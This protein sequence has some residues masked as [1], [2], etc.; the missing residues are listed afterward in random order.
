MGKRYGSKAEY[1]RL[2]KAA[3]ASDWI[4]ADLRKRAWEGLAAEAFGRE[5]VEQARTA[6]R[7]VEG[8]AEA[9]DFEGARFSYRVVT[10]PGVRLAGDPTVHDPPLVPGEV[11]EVELRFDAADG[12]R[13]VNRRVRLPAPDLPPVARCTLP[14]PRRLDDPL[15]RLV[16]DLVYGPEGLAEARREAGGREP[17]A[18]E[19]SVVTEP[20]QPDDIDL[21]P[22]LAAGEVIDA[23]LLVREADDEDAAAWREEIRAHLGLGEV[24][25]ER[26]A[27]RRFPRKALPEAEVERFREAETEEVSSERDAAAARRTI[28]F[29]EVIGPE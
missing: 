21:D 12:E 25:C 13:R 20:G 24:E 8:S 28:L 26:V 15:G 27:H 3:K 7:A 29:E 23:F 19:F 17:E 4:G 18:V 2:R 10:R 22:P 11:V 16:A 1:D 14:D 5:Q 9:G 6:L